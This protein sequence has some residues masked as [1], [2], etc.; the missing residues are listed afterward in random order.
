M[1]II[2]QVLLH[3][4]AACAGFW[5]VSGEATTPMEKSEKV[6]KAGRKPSAPVTQPD[7][8]VTEAS[9]A[10][11]SPDTWPN[12][13][14][15]VE[16]MRI[17]ELPGTLQRYLGCR[18]PDVRRRL[19]GLLFER[20]AVLDRQGALAALKGIPSPQM[21]VTALRNI[22]R[23]WV[24]TDEAAA[25]Q[26][27]VSMNDDSVLQEEGIASLLGFCTENNPTNYVA[28]AKGLEDP[29]LRGK[30][31]N[32]I[33]QSWARNDAKSALEAAF[34]EADA[35]LR[36]QL[37]EHVSHQDKAGLDYAQALDRI[38]QMPDPAERVRLISNDWASIFANRQPAEALSWLQQHA[39]RP[40][41]QEA[42]GIVGGMMAEQTK[43]VADLC[44][45]AMTLPA[46]PLRDAF[47]AAAAG[48]W[49]FRGH[50]VV[51]AEQ[52]LALCGPCIE[53]EHAMGFI[54]QRRGKP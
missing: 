52:L 7:R 37:F 23:E 16:K 4:V 3:G 44:A 36:Q 5:F 1:K 50:P 24:K 21:K 26:H 25:W 38:L 43:N 11:L 40:E 33:A 41:L 8:S 12:E 47:A 14:A 49:A 9:V 42:S 6:E 2:F 48:R 39:D 29:F 51:E 32:T 19:L 22:L 20:W 31:L 27:V 18:F 54:E 30:A 15:A 13:I 17:S 46:G 10:K 28:W 53:R 45:A 35:F 34:A